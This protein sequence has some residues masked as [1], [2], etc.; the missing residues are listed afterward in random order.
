MNTPMDSEV[1]I[2]VKDPPI[3]HEQCVYVF[4]GGSSDSLMVRYD[5]HRVKLSG[6]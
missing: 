4:M 1:I 6:R 5:A 2:A 3:S